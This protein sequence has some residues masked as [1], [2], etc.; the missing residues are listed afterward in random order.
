MAMTN[1]LGYKSKIYYWE[2]GKNINNPYSRYITLIPIHA[3]TRIG[4][5]IRTFFDIVSNKI[6]VVNVY[7]LKNESFVFILIAKVF[8][9][10]TYL[11]LDMSEETIKTLNAS[12]VICRLRRA[13]IRFFLNL[14]DTVS[15]ERLS[16]KEKLNILFPNLDVICLANGIFKDITPSVLDLPRENC[17]LIVGR[18][19]AYQKNHESILDALDKI[20]DFFDW[21][22]KFVGPVDNS[23]K[24]KLSILI[25]KKPY[26]LKNIE[27]LGE[28]DREDI[29]ELYNRSRVFL[30]PSRWEGFS[31]A[32]LEAAFSGCYILAT[33]VGGV[34]E[35]TNEGR[36]GIILKDICEL[37]SKIE[38]IVNGHIPVDDNIIERKEFIKNQFDIESNLRKIT[39]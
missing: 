12:S 31:I 37:P 14:V 27:I 32:L 33:N 36:L 29:F 21:K 6:G 10:K 20:D 23:F 28:K 26:L 15:V 16:I 13:Y 8:S 38:A 22:F 5:I 30:M 25:A 34:Y 1:I 7:H 4:F 39:W 2:K 17:F 24:S 3:K 18:I 11:K 35:V 9:I 19:G